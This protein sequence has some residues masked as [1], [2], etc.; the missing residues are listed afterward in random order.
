MTRRQLFKLALSAPLAAFGCKRM[1]DEQFKSIVTYDN[2][3]ALREWRQKIRST[4]PAH[5]QEFIRQ[6]GTVK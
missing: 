1:S 4:Y 6:H 3:K 2:A 5:I